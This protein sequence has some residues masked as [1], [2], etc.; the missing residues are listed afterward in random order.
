MIRG[1]YDEAQIAQYGIVDVR[2]ALLF[3]HLTLM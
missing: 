1:R 3:F 2:I